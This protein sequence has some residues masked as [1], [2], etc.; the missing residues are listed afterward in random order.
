[1]AVDDE[2]V[3]DHVVVKVGAD[4][5]NFA[6][7]ATA[8]VKKEQKKIPTAKVRLVA[9][10]TGFVK[11][12]QEELAKVRYPLQYKVK[13]VADSSQ[14]LKS[15]REALK[16]E[17]LKPGQL[18]YKV[19]LVA[20]ERV[21]R[22]ARGRIVDNARMIEQ[23][24]TRNAQRE[25]DNRVRAAERAE[26][27][28]IRAAQRA[29][30]ERVRAAERAARQ[31]E[32]IDRERRRSLEKSLN[33]PTLIDLG[34][35][36]F[37][38]MNLLYASVAALTPALLAMSSSALQ[39]ASSV[40][41]LGSAGIGASLALGGI[42]VSFAPVANALQLAKTVDT[43]GLVTSAKRAV[44]GA[45]DLARAQ[46][47][48]A[49]AQRDEKAAYAGIHKARQEAI[50]D[51][52]DLRKAVRD[53]DNE[54]KSNQ[55]SVAEAERD[56]R[57][58]NANFFATALDRA[59]AH[60]D[61]LD[62]RTRLKD[63]QLERKQKREDLARSL[64][65][66]IEGS[67]KVVQARERARDARDRRLNAQAA[68]A[69][70][71]QSSLGGATSAS[72]QL[73]QALAQ[74]SP[75][76]RDMY[77]W[78]RA[79]DKMLKGLQRTIQQGVLPGFTTFL[80]EIS[81]TPKGGKSTLQVAAEYAAE[82]G[83]IVSKYAG[84]FGKLTQS[85][86]FRD[87]MATMQKNNAKAFD[88][89]G[90]AIERSIRPVSRILAAA[91][92]LLV[93]FSEKLIE[94]ADR[95][96]SFIENAA[97]NGSLQKWFAD[98][99]Y[100]AGL[101][102]DV[103]SNIGELLKNVFLQS[104]PAG[105][106]LVESLRDFTADLAKW[107]GSGS[108]QKE[109]KEFFQLFADLPYA[110]IR[111]FL[112]QF[113]E[114]FTVMRLVPWALTNPFFA[115]L[116]ILATSNMGGA[117]TLLAGIAKVAETVGGVIA[118]HPQ[119]TAFLLGLLSLSKLSK[120]GGG[121]LFKLAGLDKLTDLLR[122]K[123]AVLDK[124]IGGGAKTGVMNVQAAVVNIY[125]GA[126]IPG[127][128]VGGG[129]PGRAGGAAAGAGRAGGL[130]AGMFWP[131]MIAA[132]AEFTFSEEGKRARIATQTAVIHAVGATIGVISSRSL[133]ERIKNPIGSVIADAVGI[134][135][136]LFGKDKT[137]EQSTFDALRKAAI[138]S[139]GKGG[140][141]VFTSPL[142]QNYITARKASVK[143]AVDKAREEQGPEAARR[144][145]LLETGASVRALSAQLQLFGRGKDEADAYAKAVFDLNSMLY[146]SKVNSY[147]AAGAVDKH[148]TS[149]QNAGKKA[150]EVRP[151]IT[152]L[153]EEVNK[154][155]GDKQ[156]S[157]TLDGVEEVK[158]NLE[159]LA[160][161]QQLLRQNKP[162]TEANIQRQKQIFAKNSGGGNTFATE[163]R[164]SG[165][166]V[167]GYSPHPKADNIPAWLTANEYVQ[168]VSA[169]KYYGT[170]FMD[171][172]RSRQFPRFAA[173]GPV[174][175]WPF[176]VKVPKE[177]GEIEAGMGW[178]PYTGPAPKG[179]GAIKGLTDKMAI[180]A[181]DAAANAGAHVV[182]GLRPGAI[183]VTGNRSY[184]GYGRAVDF[185]P[186]SMQLFEY[187]KNKYDGAIRELIYSPA[188]KRQVWNGKPHMY[189]GA[190][191]ATHW[192]HVHL[193]MAQGGQV[194][195]RTYDSGGYLPPGY[196]LAFNGTRQPET[197]R[198]ARQE[199]AL[200]GPMRLDR[201]DL[202][203]LAASMQATAPGI[204]N[205][206]G[207][208]VAEL[209][210]RYNYVPSGV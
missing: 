86:F 27:Q 15:A 105:G 157:F 188:G 39:A 192:D 84:Q 89:L 8:G 31:Q 143:T 103:L 56:E 101:W 126:G 57:A 156:I 50:R 151:K 186:P 19:K 38:P 87:D 51:L 139:K 129:A 127:G 29:E 60:Q 35:E 42:A 26:Q 195:A 124:F 53:L 196:S 173:G 170:D 10:K 181:I 104:L 16:K 137:R 210:N 185:A 109:I 194:P 36:G 145:Q 202:A 203:L 158:T 179:V 4:T 167:G 191:R 79:N 62:A 162:F 81:K 34:G 128:G 82:L 25:N 93:S 163:Q 28:K 11:S 110:Q 107:S 134:A 125:G 155:T 21:G 119:A 199:A 69:R 140:A 70:K 197:I 98:A 74:M 54:Y 165:G 161:Y 132:L 2:D 94:I 118:A 76:A 144:L 174:D 85:P 64:K 172:I 164:A 166:V 148:G 135:A 58:T 116:G 17:A 33:P 88:N 72:E 46:R 168:P 83:G 6:K 73:Q 187:L 205:M 117:T 136:A 66:G 13:L 65:S 122:G 208:R 147:L 106:S 37:R 22:G 200:R 131:A 5:D 209:T 20:D 150:D 190:V 59:R 100:Q 71:M 182:S 30:T 43:Q 152:I 154:L 178:T 176:V 146:E 77:D 138:G 183:T 149:M 108:G 48:I 7:E 99:A 114:V 204:V 115:A 47:D 113:A 24:I 171:A 160:A 68:S 32:K 142:V 198:T 111:D 184:H 12:A 180:A 201:R 23:V 55:I 123:F 189:T 67:D 159:G 112:I 175:K 97:R 207:R 1:M 91:S 130:L 52:E 63:T 90:Q 41:A 153:N 120:G 141:G 133:A 75:A 177:A 92:P 49:A 96:D 169:V 44:G 18:E 40:A 206:D 14:F 193:A 9:D 80:R 121:I 78:F 45:D 95:F 61:T 3:I 102:W